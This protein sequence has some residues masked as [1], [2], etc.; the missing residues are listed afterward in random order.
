MSQTQCSK[1]VN[2]VTTYLVELHILVQDV[3]LEGL[4]MLDRD[5]MV[6]VLHN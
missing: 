1:S 6:E 3:L 2:G 4:H 5:V